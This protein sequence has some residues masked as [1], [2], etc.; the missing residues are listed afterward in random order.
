MLYMSV[1][2]L[3]REEITAETE[4]GRDLLQS[5]REKALNFGSTALLLD[6]FQ[7]ERYSAVHYDMTLVM[8]LLQQKIAEARTN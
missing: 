5:Y 8:Q 4:L 1:Y 6:P 3:I 2:Q 7:E